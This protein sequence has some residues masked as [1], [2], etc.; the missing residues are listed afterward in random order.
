MIAVGLHPLK[1]GGHAGTG[2]PEN[3]VARGQHSTWR[4]VTASP[5]SDVSL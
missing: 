5:P 1:D 2:S 3:T 4:T